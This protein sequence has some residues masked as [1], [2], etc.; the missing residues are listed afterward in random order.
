[1]H[2]HSPLWHTQIDTSSLG[3]PPSTYNSIHLTS[4]LHHHTTPGT[5]VP[6][7]SSSRIPSAPKLRHHRVLPSLRSFSPPVADTFINRPE[8]SSA[9]LF[10][11]SQA[12]DTIVPSQSLDSLKL[13]RSLN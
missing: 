8:P 10:W 12:T 1:M 4:P 11:T 7:S 6:S 9:S 5:A 3:L 13:S 2:H